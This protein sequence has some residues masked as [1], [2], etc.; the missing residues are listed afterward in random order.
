MRWFLAVGFAV[1]VAGGAL[2]LVQRR[3][4]YLPSGS[5][6]P[7]PEGWQSVTFDAEDGVVLDGWFSPPQGDGALV[8]VFNG[9]AGN[10][11]DR[12]GLGSRLT[13][14]GLGVVLFD[15]RG[16]GGNPGSP[17]EEGLADDAAAVA[18][19]TETHHPDRR[20]VYFGESLGAAVAIRLATERP[21]AALV[22][23]SP[24]TSLPAAAAV[25]YPFLP[26]HRLL[27]DVYPS[28]DRIGAVTA[29]V[30]VIAG[31]ADAIVPVE[32]SRA[33]FDAAAE[34]KS[35]L[36]IEGADHNDPALAGG[37]EVVAAIL[38]ATR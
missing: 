4:I 24:F 28:I 37:E 26:V 22:L 31:S 23:R 13:A 17:S 33:I 8:V 3:I 21:P 18:A 14:E 32:Q 7:P 35:W 19:W 11:A 15:Y 10:R 5:P 36:L 30:T 9:N 27:W 16:Y 1:L 6:G 29:P 34:P 20:V 38:G 12:I 25:H 2:W